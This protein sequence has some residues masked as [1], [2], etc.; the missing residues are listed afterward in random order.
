M[1]FDGDADWLLDDGSHDGGGIS[2]IREG[3]GSNHTFCIYAH[4]PDFIVVPEVYPPGYILKIFYNP[5]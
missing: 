5:L 3:R 1:N 2:S 4:D